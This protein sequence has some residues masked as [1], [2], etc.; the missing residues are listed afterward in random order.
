MLK[1]SKDQ[2]FKKFLDTVKGKENLNEAIYD[3][4]QKYYSSYGYSSG[5]TRKR[6][7]SYCQELIEDTINNEGSS[8][9]EIERA[10]LFG[11][12]VLDAEKYKLNILRAK[13][14][15]EIQELY[16]KYVLGMNYIKEGA[17]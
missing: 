11:Y 5:S 12:V 17:E 4:R 13:E 1:K 3:S 9:A 15:L 2:E 14:D 8:V 6:Y 16:D 7:F 10:I